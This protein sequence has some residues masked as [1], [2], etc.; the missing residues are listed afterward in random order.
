M[1]IRQRNG[2]GVPIVHDVSEI[3]IQDWSMQ[4]QNIIERAFELARGSTSIEE[5]R[6]TLRREG[7]S[8]V[9]AHLGGASIKADLKKRFAR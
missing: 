1:S 9:D 5:I 4:T 7:Y 2:I 3:F 6:K 8:N